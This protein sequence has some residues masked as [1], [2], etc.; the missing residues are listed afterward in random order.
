MP[1]PMA[2][3]YAA[4]AADRRRATAGPVA[5]VPLPVLAA[6]LTTLA[7]VEPPSSL[8]V[9]L[10]E[11]RSACGLGGLGPG[12]DPELAVDGLDVAVHGAV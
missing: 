8:G 11:S 7:A 1:D 9:V 10:H 4:S 2:A 3:G 12:A 6:R 5:A